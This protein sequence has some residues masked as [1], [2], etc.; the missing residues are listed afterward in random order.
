MIILDRR[1]FQMG[2]RE[3]VYLKFRGEIHED[4][5]G[6]I[7]PFQIFKCINIYTATLR[8]LPLDFGF[9]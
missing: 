3:G 8:G 4:A 7:V 2:L 1:R 9:T 6:T 5:K